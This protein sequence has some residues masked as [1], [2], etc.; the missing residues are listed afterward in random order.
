MGICNSDIII[1]G[2]KGNMI[3]GYMFRYNMM[4]QRM[5]YVSEKGDH[6]P[7][8]LVPNPTRPYGEIH[9]TMGC[10]GIQFMDTD[11]G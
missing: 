1:N 10:N 4:M 6:Y 11:I 5:E 2:N 9:D 8:W 3:W 7:T